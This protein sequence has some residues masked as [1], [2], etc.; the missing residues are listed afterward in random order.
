MNLGNL[1]QL[2]NS[3][4]TFTQN[5]PKF[6]DFLKAVKAKGAVPGAEIT[7]T[8]SYPDGETLKAGLKLRE[9]DAQLINN[10]I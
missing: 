7:I 3:W 5:H 6:P 2:K 1:M 10:L 8:V 4:A 9:S